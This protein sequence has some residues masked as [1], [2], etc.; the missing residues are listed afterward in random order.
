ML[1]VRIAVPAERGDVT[2]AECAVREAAALPIPVFRSGVEV[3]SALLLR[4][5][6]RHGEAA[7][8]LRSAERRERATGRCNG[9][10]MVLAHQVEAA[11]ERG[12]AGAARDADDE[13]Q[14]F[15]SGE[16]AVALTMRQLLARAAVRADEDAA[17]AARELGARHGLAVDAAQA[18]GLLGTSRADADLLV[19]AHV[20]LGRLG[21]SVRQRP[22]ARA[23]RGLG[24]RVPTDRRRVDGLRPVEVDIVGLVAAGL[25]NR[26]IGQR[27]GL[28]P[29]TIEVYLSRIY[30]KTGHRS[31]SNWPS[32]HATASWDGVERVSA[33]SSADAA[34]RS[35]VSDHWP[36][37]RPPGSR[38]PRLFSRGPSRGRAPAARRGSGRR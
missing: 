31:T 9:L 10:A 6:G 27:T 12:D 19:D 34:V 35:A 5:R 7:A 1:A 37:A 2:A 33:G 26:Q 28:S 16:E 3:A 24:R 22:V 30:A 13:L 4:A 32:L 36:P 8:V 11:L 18:L 25:S 23:L 29:K 38:R 20:E 17:A 15:P 14:S 21:A